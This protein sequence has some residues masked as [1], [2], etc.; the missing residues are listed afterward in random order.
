MA[1]GLRLFCPLELVGDE[2]PGYAKL[3]VRSRTELAIRLHSASPDTV[4]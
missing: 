1:E 4:R 2:G 3:R